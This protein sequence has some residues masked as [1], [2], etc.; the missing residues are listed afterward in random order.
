MNLWRFL[1]SNSCDKS[2]IEA[3]WHV[4]ER[5]T[6]R[7]IFHVCRSW[8]FN[9]GL[10]TFFANRQ[11]LNSANWAAEYNKRTRVVFSI[12]SFNSLLQSRR[13]VMSLAMTRTSWKE[14]KKNWWEKKYE[15]IDGLIW[16]MKEQERERST[17]SYIS[18]TEDNKPIYVRNLSAASRIIFNKYRKHN[19]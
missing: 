1:E 14:M 17:F 12:F 9:I 7:R 6:G 15:L 16:F 5:D 10:V 18:K 2:G 3:Y 4:K 13:G 8:R 19:R 11:V